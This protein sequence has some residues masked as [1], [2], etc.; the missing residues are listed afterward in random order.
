MKK[1]IYLLGC[2]M[3]TLEG[4]TAGAQTLLQQVDCVI[5]TSRLEPLT[6]VCRN[7]IKTMPIA[8]M[9]PYLKS[10]EDASFCV[11]AS[12]DVGFYSIATTL[13]QA[14]QEEADFE[15]VSGTSSLQYLT[16][17]CN[18]GYESVYCVSL[19]G[20]NKSLLPYVTYHAQVFCL[21]GGENTVEKI[22]DDLR[23]AG[24]QEVFV[25]VGENLGSEAERIV[26]GTPRSLQA[27]VF[28][29]LA[30]LL[31][32]NPQAADPQKWLRDTDF[33]RGS[34]PMSKE[35]VRAIAVSML[36]VRSTDVVY[37][38]GAGTGA[39]TLTLAQRA[40]ESMVYAV[41][42]K[43]EA[44]VLVRENQKRHG[45]YNIR[46][47]HEAA[48]FGLAEFP[49]PDKV[50]IGGSGGDLEDILGV[51]LQRNPKA[52]LL[53]AAVTLE[54]LSQATMLMERFALQTELVCLNVA[55]AT[56]LGSYHL[57]QAENPVYLIKGVKADV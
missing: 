44:V 40:S 35:G 56:E 50:F 11:L 4:M 25:T 23:K 9:V 2:G 54:T 29:G 7:K 10:S 43:E 51:V 30:V 41:E 20:R 1:K 36:D 16:A 28:E 55:Q 24:L 39:M 18:R 22:L 34:V 14:L 27:E 13:Q 53:I 48:P 57:M 38:I 26:R 12:G 8:E 32:D 5:T 17:A 15:W 49:S 42:R 3:G 46:L 33:V 19:H 45:I 52:T 31:V 37:D 6:A 21:T 47:I